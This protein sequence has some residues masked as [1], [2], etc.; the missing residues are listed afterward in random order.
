[1]SYNSN[2]VLSCADSH[3]L[4]LYRLSKI[5]SEGIFDMDSGMKSNRE[6]ITVS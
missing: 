2:T 1:M 3:I 6:E 5:S 4:N